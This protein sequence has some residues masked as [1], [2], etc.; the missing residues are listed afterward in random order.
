M[1]RMKGELQELLKIEKMMAEKNGIVEDDDLEEDDVQRRKHLVMIKLAVSESLDHLRFGKEE[2]K[3]LEFMR[4]RRTDSSQERIPPK[5]PS[6]GKSSILH[7]NSAEEFLRANG[8]TRKK[9]ITQGMRELNMVCVF[10]SRFPGPIYT[11]YIFSKTHTGSCKPCPKDSNT[12]R[13]KNKCSG[14]GAEYH[15]RSEEHAYNGHGHISGART[16]SWKS[17]DASASSEKA[18]SRR[19]T[20]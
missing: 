16:E 14:R 12:V 17:A 6:N 8:I 2:L 5:K 20:V 10:F 19:T 3:M 1:K 11:A 9:D 13:G 18:K 15:V 7:I 4:S